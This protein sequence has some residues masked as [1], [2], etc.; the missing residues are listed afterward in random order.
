M[1]EAAGEIAARLRAAHSAHIYSHFDPDGITSGSIMA[2]A[3]EREGLEA[4]VTFLKKLSP[5]AVEAIRDENPELAVF[6]DFGSGM[7]PSLAGLEAVVI[8]HH[9]PAELPPEKRRDLIEL[10][11]TMGS[12]YH[13]NP[14]LY[15]RDGGFEVSS[16]GLAYLV[17]RAL[18][19]GANADLIPLAVVGALGDQQDRAHGRLVSINAEL[20]VDGT[21]GGLLE[22]RRDLRL[23]GRETKPLHRLLQYATDPPLPRI[24]GDEE[25]AIVFCLELGIDLKDGEG[26]WRRWPDL[27]TWEK[28]RVLSELV[29]LLIEGGHGHREASRLLGEVYLLAREAP[30]SMFRDAREYATLLN[31]CGRYDHPEVGMQLCLGDRGEALERAT[32]LLKDHRDHLVESLDFIHEKGVEEYGSLQYYHGGDRIRETVIGVTAGMLLGSPSVARDKPLVA[33][34]NAEDGVKV[35]ARAPGRLTARGLDLATAVRE[36]AE[37][38]GGYGGGHGAAAGAIIPSGSEE[39]FLRH[40]DALVR[41]QMGRS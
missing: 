25:A 12:L 28:K 26:T 10:A 39:E 4:Q 40:L 3:L 37:V 13:F 14:H 20:V 35:S 23:F 34:A 22:C 31:A 41:K 2:K 36:A 24:S 1:Q 5:G 7:I 8:D 17:A 32:A 33:F 27:Q 18:D 21:R 29:K 30:G 9:V 38:V 16:S 11:K 6:T 19:P 15:G